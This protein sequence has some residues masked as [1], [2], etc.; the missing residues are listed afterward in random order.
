MFPYSRLRHYKLGLSTPSAEENT[1]LLG[2]TGMGY[3]KE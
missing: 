2:A 1:Y 3:N